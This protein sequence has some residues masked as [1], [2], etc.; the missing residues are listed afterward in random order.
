M[1]TRIVKLTFKEEHISKFKDI[2]NQ[3]RAKIAGFEGCHFVEMLQSK[4]SDNICFT[5]SI[6]DSE[7]ALNYYRHSELFKNTWAKTKVLFDDKPEAWSTESRGFEGQLKKE[8][9]EKGKL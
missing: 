8:N 1:I 6:W 2:W 9:N 7:D 4:H 3:S 5:Y